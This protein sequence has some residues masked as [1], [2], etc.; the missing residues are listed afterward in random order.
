MAIDSVSSATAATLAL[1]TPQRPRPDDAQRTTPATTER[2]TN[3]SPESRRTG[4]A[5]GASQSQDAA[6]PE[7][8]AQRP[9]E[10][11]D[12]PAASDGQTRPTLNTAGQTVGR[13]VD[14]T[15]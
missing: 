12:A 14:T 5:Q 2:A 9:A 7:R 8:A 11:S 4:N 1:Q 6:Q 10:A 13:I 3:E 15:A